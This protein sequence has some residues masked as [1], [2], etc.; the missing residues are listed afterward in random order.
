ME[1]GLKDSKI[2]T[3]K[4][5]ACPRPSK[6]HPCPNKRHPCPSKRHQVNER[7]SN[8]QL[9]STPNIEYKKSF[10]YRIFAWRLLTE[11]LH[12]TLLPIQEI[13][14]KLVANSRPYKEQCCEFIN[15]YGNSLPIQEL[16]WNIVTNSRP[17]MEH[18]CQFNNLC[19]T[20]L[21][22]QEL[23]RKLVANLRTC[24]EHCCQFKNLY[25]TLLPI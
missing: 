6:G 7:P 16:V 1:K 13:V 21:P 19:G 5:S 10:L 8:G 11:E 15:L 12:E 4:T 24:M 2:K 3:G 22:I 25:G 9:R 18:S 23:V 20:L 14:W 17:C